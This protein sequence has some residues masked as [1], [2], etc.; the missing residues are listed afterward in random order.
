M[1][2]N[3]NLDIVLGDAQMGPI[4][5]DLTAAKNALGAIATITL[6]DEESAQLNKVNNARLP[7]VLRAVTEFGNSYAN[8]VS[9][10]VTTARAQN[11]F[12][13]L[14]SLRQLEVQLAEF[15]DRVKDLSFNVEEIVYN[16]T[17]DMYANAKRYRGDVP[18]ADTVSDYLSGMFEG[19]GNFNNDQDNPPQ[20]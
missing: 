5:A 3:P 13:A 15:Q 6:S 12:E 2:F 18:G 8:L 19:Q 7:F 4:L 9:P 10:R 16:Y 17:T 1:P 11:L 20:P 14:V